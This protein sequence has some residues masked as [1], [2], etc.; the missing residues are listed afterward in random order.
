MPAEVVVHRLPAQRLRRLQAEGQ[1]ALD[2]VTEPVEAAV[3]DRVLQPGMAA[4]GAVPIVALDRDHLSCHLDHLM[5][6]DECERLR[7]GDE[8]IRL[9]VRP[10]QAAT[11]KHVEAAD[12]PVI[13]THGD[14]GQ[15]VC[16]DVDA[17]VALDR[18]RRLELSGQV[19]LAVQGLC[20]RLRRADHLT[21][22]PDL[23]I[24]TSARRERRHHVGDGVI[25]LLVEPIGPRLWAAHDVAL[26]VAAATEG[27][28]QRF[29]DRGDRLLDVALEDSVELEVLPG[30]DAQRPIRPAL[31]DGVVSQVGVGGDDPAGDPCP[32]HQ[33]VM[34][35]Q[36]AS[37]GFFA[38]VPV[39]LLVDAVELQELLGVVRECGRVLHQL[40][41]DQ[42]AQMIAGGLDRF[43]PGQIVQGYAV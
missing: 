32:D 37:P 22:E 15:V 14:E 10:A 38:T 3:G 42:A 19:L 21:V 33:L 43:V 29:V 39:V 6:F 30:R 25:E 2:L 31:A 20:L 35:V 27:R 8:R 41:L 9:V 4:I 16:I 13:A 18:D 5:R 11:D 7:D 28:Q 40:F 36:A 17:V 12:G 1:P 23:V 24:R 34:L 26:D